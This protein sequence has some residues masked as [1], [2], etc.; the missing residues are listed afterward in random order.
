MDTSDRVIV[1]LF[2]V[3]LWALVTINSNNITKIE[4]GI[5]KCG[6]LKVEK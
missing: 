3:S 2:V 1:L 6:Y 4:E 5:Y